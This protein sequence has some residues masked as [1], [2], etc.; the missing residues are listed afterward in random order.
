MRGTVVGEFNSLLRTL[1][2]KDYKLIAINMRES[3]AIN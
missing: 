1:A 3:E 2:S